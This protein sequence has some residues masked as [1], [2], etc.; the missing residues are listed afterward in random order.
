MHATA[1]FNGKVVAETDA[2][3]FVEGNFPPSSVD[4]SV[5]SKT[6]LTTVCPWKGTASYYD[7]TVDG[8]SARDAAWYY[9]KTE[10][11]RASKLKDHIAFFQGRREPTALSRITTETGVNEGISPDLKPKASSQVQDRANAVT[12]E[13]YERVNGSGKLFLTSGVINGLYAIRVISANQKTNEQSLRAGFEL[14]VDIAEEILG[15]AR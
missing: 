2:F 12:K 4:Q 14:I 9:P 8:K 6:S 1:T 3:E 5:L 11:E 7:I 10:T 15:Q 13:V